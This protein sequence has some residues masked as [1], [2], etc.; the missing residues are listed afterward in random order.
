MLTY[1]PSEFSQVRGQYRHTDYADGPTR[2]SCC[3][4][5]SFPSAPMARIRSRYRYGIRYQFGCSSE[6]LMRMFNCFAFVLALPLAPS[7]RAS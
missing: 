6:M 2:T 7:P 3:S 4:S 5:S 1:W